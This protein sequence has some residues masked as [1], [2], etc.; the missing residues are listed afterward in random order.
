MALVNVAKAKTLCPVCG[1]TDWCMISNDGKLALC[2]RIENN[3]P[4]IK[5]GW[6]H[7]LEDNIRY[8]KRQFKKKKEKEKA[9]DF[10][11]D[12]VYSSLLENLDLTVEHQNELKRRGMNEN[13]IKYFNYKSL[14]A[15]GRY[16][17]TKFLDNKFGPNV[18][19]FTPGFYSK[20]G[21]YGE[22]FTIAGG[23]GFMIPVKNLDKQT[24]GIQIRVDHPTKNTKYVWL[25]STDKTYGTNSGTPL[26]V[27]FPPKIESKNIWITEGPLKANILA[28]RN[29]CIVIAAPGI[30]HWR[31]IPQ[32]VE[33]INRFYTTNNTCII[34]YDADYQEKPFV[35]EHAINLNSALRNNSINVLFATWELTRG[36]GIDDII[37]NNGEINLVT[38][39]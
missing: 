20:D 16:K 39:I 7:S 23:S 13:E 26:H 24:C 38:S 17:V 5:G 1:K 15:R 34:A 12:Q 22:Y 11:L 21:K 30:A 4:N 8:D 35:K 9:P 6:W 28:W 19:K 10:I 32:V 18:L 27:A 25:S 29:K 2:Q 37:V 31:E 3:H 33:K 14:Q 36:K